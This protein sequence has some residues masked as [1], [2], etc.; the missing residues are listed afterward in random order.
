MIS[1]ATNWHDAIGKAIKVTLSLAKNLK[2]K[3]DMIAPAIANLPSIKKQSLEKTCKESF[4]TVI[5]M[6]MEGQDAFAAGA[7]GTVHTKLSAALDTECVDELSKCWAYFPRS[8]Q[9]R[10]TS[11]IVSICLAIMAQNEFVV[12]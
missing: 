11:T 12:P 9:G 2:S 8:Q 10:G 3:N 6:L 7:N 5:D 4:Q 1:G